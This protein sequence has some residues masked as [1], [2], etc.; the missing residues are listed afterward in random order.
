MIRV[1]IKSYLKKFLIYQL[2]E[3]VITLKK[4][5]HIDIE[6]CKDETQR[7]K[8]VRLK[9]ITDIICGVG[10]ITSNQSYYKEPTIYNDFIGLELTGRMKRTGQLYVNY[11]AVNTM[12]ERIYKWFCYDITSY[13]DSEVSDNVK[14]KN[15]I[16]DV[17]N[18]YNIQ[19]EELGFDGLRKMY[20]RNRGRALKNVSEISAQDKVVLTLSL[21][22]KLKL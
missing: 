22:E 11:Q 3:D 7:E 8:L 14:L 4:I 13:L 20:D 2:Q 18:K 6:K 17:M 12:N 9:Q 15:A 1:P 21:S 5:T 19:L 10:L 16:Y